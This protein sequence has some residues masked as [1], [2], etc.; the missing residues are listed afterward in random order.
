MRKLAIA[1]RQ[2]AGGELRGA[3]AATEIEKRNLRAAALGAMASL[4][5]SDDSIVLLICHRILTLVG[6]PN[7]Y[8]YGERLS[9]P[10]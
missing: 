6:G 1:Q 5:V 9:A 7:K 8:Y 4:C 2:E 3:T 10:I